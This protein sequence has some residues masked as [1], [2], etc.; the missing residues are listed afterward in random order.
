MCSETQVS[1]NS[2]ARLLIQFS[3]SPLKRIMAGS[4]V[5][6]GQAALFSCF[7]A[8]PFWG[9]ANL[10]HEK[11]QVSVWLPKRQGGPPA[12]AQYWR[13]A[14]ITSNCPAHEEQKR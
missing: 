12:E 10:Q 11:A 3:C 14:P 1:T 5:V 13:S 4:R 9:A 8:G 6:T 2:S 7:V